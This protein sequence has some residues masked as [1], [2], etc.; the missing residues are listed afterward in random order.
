VLDSW[1]EKSKARVK[2]WE[3]DQNRM[4]ELMEE[5]GSDRVPADHQHD[6][7]VTT[8]TPEIQARSITY[9]GIAFLVGTPS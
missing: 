1:F 6:A 4:S 5:E 7:T 8:Q 2:Q 9:L 3:Y